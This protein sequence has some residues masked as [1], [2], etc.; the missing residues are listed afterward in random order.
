M[1]HKQEIK[2]LKRDEKGRFMKGK[3][4]HLNKKELYNL[5]KIKEFTK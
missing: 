5:N 2:K 1:I 4:I 3:V